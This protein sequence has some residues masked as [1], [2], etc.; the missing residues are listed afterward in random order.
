[1]PR[2][3]NYNSKYHDDWAWSLAVKGA[4]TQEIA[5]AFGFN[6]K[7]IE[8]WAKDH[9]SFGEALKAGKDIADSHVERKLYQ[10]AMG[11]ETTDE[12]TIV[13]MGND[14][15]P[16]PLKIRKIKKMEKP[17]MGAIA[18]W[19]K[20]RRPEE[21]CDH[22]ELKQSKLSTICEEWLQAVV[23]AESDADE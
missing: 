19:L 10:L 5:D 16:K 13:E 21:Y 14:G 9:P 3:S 20:N 1:M 2:P 8:R 4:D 17:K 15:S 7:T 18:F 6:K 11:F 12:E 22:P 23:D